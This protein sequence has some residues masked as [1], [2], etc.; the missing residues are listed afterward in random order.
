[1]FKIK[2]LIV[3]T[4]ISGAGKTAALNALEDME[5]L[6]MD[7][8]PCNFATLIL[9]GYISEIKQSKVDKIAL[10]M[11][12]RSFSAVEEYHNFLN[13]MEKHLGDFQ[14]IFLDA[15][16]EAILNRYNLTRRRH[17]VVADTLLESIE[18]ERKIMSSIKERATRV[19]DTSFTSAKQLSEKLKESHYFRHKDAEKINIHIQSFGYKYGMPID[20]DL[21]FDVR[22]LP[23]PYYIPEL[24]EKTGNDIEVQTYVMDSPVSHEFYGKLLNMLEFLIPN[25]IAEGKKH[26]SI[27]IGCSGGKHRSVTFVNY[28]A[29][30]LKKIKNLKIYA[31]HKE[32]EKGHW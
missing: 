12:V 24:K 16:D 15:S 19:I 2:S 26:L 32:N 28:L 23:N 6:T 25:Y 14:V 11:D 10:G 4:G 17:P 1:M 30:D 18:N 3:V 13:N 27:G 20:L 7:N 21:A 9:E 8:I 22:F 29:R 31:S 5:Y